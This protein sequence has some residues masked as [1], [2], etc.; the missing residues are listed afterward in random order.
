MPFQKFAQ[1][2]IHREGLLNPAKCEIIYNGIEL[3]RYGKTANRDL[4]N[5]LGL[6]D[7]AILVGSLGNVRPAKAYDLL[8][9][10][11]R[12]IVDVSPQAHFVIAGDPK[13]SLQR[14]LDRLAQELGV[15]GHVHFIS[16]NSQ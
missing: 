2:A 14:E 5:Q 7:E 1:D 13:T 10:A 9:K 8:I 6:A 12:R 15:S 16:W 11:A 4:R 3:S